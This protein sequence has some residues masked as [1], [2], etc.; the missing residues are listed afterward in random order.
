[1]PRLIFAAAHQCHAPR[2]RGLLGHRSERRRPDTRHAKGRIARKILG[3]L[4]S[5]R[6]LETQIDLDF[7]GLLQRARDLNRLQSAQRGPGP[8]DQFTEPQQE[9]EIAGECSRDPRPQDFDGDLSSL[10]GH[11][12]MDLRNRGSRDRYV[13]EGEKQAVERTAEL[14]L[15]HRARLAGRKWWQPVLQQRQIG[16]DLIA[17]QIGPRRQHLAELDKG[18]TDFLKGRG[19]ALSRAGRATVPAHDTGEPQQ[20]H[21]SSQRLQ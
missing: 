2:R 16:G 3:K 11:R 21:R 14:G 4:G 5:S 10:A 15:D 7:D 18:R 9:I 19:E 1:M 13:V 8:L 6:S 17:E 12:E 20:R